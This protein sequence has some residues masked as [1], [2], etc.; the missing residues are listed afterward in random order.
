[1]IHRDEVIGYAE[2][3]RRVAAS[4]AAL[5]EAGV[6]PGERVAVLMDKG[7]EQ[8]VAVLATSVV[9]AAYV[10]IAITQPMA[11]RER[12]IGRAG[13]EV[14]LTQSWLS[15]TGEI[16]ATARPIAVDLLPGLD[17]V[18]EA[19]GDPDTPAYVIYTSGST[20]EPK[21]VV[22]TH[23]AA[24][25]TIDD[26]NDRFGLTPG[27]RVLGVASLAFDLSVWD[28]FGVLAAGGAVVLPEQ[29]RATDPS[30]WLEL[31]RQHSVTLWN[32]VPGQ[33]QML[34]DVLESTPGARA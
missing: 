11:R 6:R 31:I 13:A 26:I 16:P 34:L 7:P 15:D 1:M 25:N 17:T 22:V 30:H 3:R 33:L 28:I 20:G 14:V 9:G 27:D 4:A 23:R 21:G 5:R 10:P 2:L 32:S 18:P 19:V 8:V 24:A 29:G 12:I